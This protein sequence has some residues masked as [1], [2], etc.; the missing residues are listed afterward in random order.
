MV[1]DTEGAQLDAVALNDAEPGAEV[2]LLKGK[3]AK[4]PP[5]EYTVSAEI[6]HGKTHRASVPLTVH[7][8][9]EHEV[10]IGQNGGLRVDGEP[11]VPVGWFTPY[12]PDYDE[13]RS[14][15]YN[16]LT[17][18]NAP[19]RTVEVEREQYLD[20]AARRGLKTMIYPWPRKLHY[21]PYSDHLRNR[22]AEALAMIR[23]RV[24]ALRDHPGLLAWYM[25]DEPGSQPETVHLVRQIYETVRAA[26]PY[27]P[28]VILSDKPDKAKA[29][30][31]NGDILV[32]DPYPGFI[33]GGRS[34]R[35]IDIVWRDTGTWSDFA[36]LKPVWVTPQGH[37]LAVY[38]SAGHRAP[39]FV[40]IRNMA[41]QSLC[42]E[43]RGWLWFRWRFGMNW[44]VVKIGTAY[45]G[46]ELLAL[47]GFILASESPARGDV[48]V[49]APDG[50][51][52]SLR[53][54]AG[55]TMLAVVNTRYEPI[56]FVLDGLPLSGALRVV[57][58]D[59]TVTC[60]RGRLADRLPPVGARVYTSAPL[61]AGERRL[62]DV[63]GEIDTAIAARGRAGNLAWVG[64]GV[65]A[66]GSSTSV[67]YAIDGCRALG[68]YRFH[69]GQNDGVQE[70]PYWLELTFPRSVTIARAVLYGSPLTASLHVP[71]AGKWRKI[72]A[73]TIDEQEGT[74]SFAPVKT[75][76]L[77]LESRNKPSICELEVYGPGGATR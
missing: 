38:G 50:F 64:R 60:H 29:H 8:S 39:N 67:Y 41:Y 7:A 40:E 55:Q 31:G 23:K 25:A 61:F 68:S 54:A 30:A 4:L 3:L 19:F 35:A 37:D 77:R 5:G 72:A 48:K 42:A 58:E 34:A 36:G 24:A 22:E 62:R 49:A 20:E 76:K 66:A 11:F 71:A 63:Q 59:S 32:A 47:Q 53:E 26:D 16:F 33:R 44:P 69:I 2:V 28:C 45:V 74:T 15:G 13:Y 51:C 56:E 70:P 46:R 6:A 12:P 17:D 27:H 10:V 57:S 1:T 9:A 21:A 75:Q 73:I 65:Q 14:E 18:Y 52:W 43:A